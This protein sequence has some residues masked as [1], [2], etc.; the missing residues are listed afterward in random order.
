MSAYKQAV[1]RIHNHA[2]FLKNDEFDA[3]F[4]L[5]SSPDSMAEFI[6]SKGCLVTTRHDLNRRFSGR[7]YI[8]NLVT[9]LVVLHVTTK[10]LYTLHRWEKN[11][12]CA[13][14][15]RLPMAKEAYLLSV[16]L[17]AQAA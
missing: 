5:N 7:D 1:D 11:A 3:K 17:E 10:G 12:P 8:V 4:L 15:N 16:M 14:S 9:D 6:K 13:T 2:G